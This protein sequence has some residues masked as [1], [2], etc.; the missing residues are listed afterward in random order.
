[1]R[2]TADVTGGKPIA[3]WSQSISA[4]SAINSYDYNIMIGKL[5]V[6]TYYY[7]TK[8]QRIQNACILLT[9]YLHMGSHTS[10]VQIAIQQRNFSSRL[11]CGNSILERQNVIYDLRHRTQQTRIYL[12]IVKVCNASIFMFVPVALL[13]QEVFYYRNM[14]VV[15]VCD[16]SRVFF[17]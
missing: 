16:F 5:V 12:Y 17:S 7:R 4:V 3:V 9:K 2:N 13:G 8:P 10:I 1:M 15:S 11:L 14:R 6:P